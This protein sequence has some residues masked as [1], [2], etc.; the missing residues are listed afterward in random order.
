MNLDL[1]RDLLHAINNNLER[2]EE[3]DAENRKRQDVAILQ[4]CSPVDKEASRIP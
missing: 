4:G 1:L 2:K 3:E